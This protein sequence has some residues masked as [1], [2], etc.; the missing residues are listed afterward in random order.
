G[1]L[2]GIEH[3]QEFI[4][5]SREVSK[6]KPIIITKSGST[7]AGTRAASSHTGSLTGSEVAF[8]A[9]FKQAGI[10]RAR[11]IEELFNYALAFAYQPLPQGPNLA[12][13]TNA[14]GPGILA[15]DSAEKNGINLLSLSK[16]TTDKLMALLPPAA[17]VYNPVDILGDA[18]AQRYQQALE[19][20]LEDPNVHGALVILT[21]QAMTEVTQTAEVIGEISMTAGKPIMTSFMGEYAV[22]EGIERLAKYKIPNYSY[23]EHAIESFSMM[24]RYRGWQGQ[25]PLTYCP[26]EGDKARVRRIIEQACESGRLEIG[27]LKAREIL[28]AYQ[29]E[30][31]AG[32]VAED[33]D[34]AA[35]LAEGIGYPVVM[36][37]VSPDIL[38]KSDVG[39]VK[40]G[41]KNAEE[42]QTA[43]QEIMFRVRKFMPQALINGVSIQKM[44]DGSRE[45]IL[46]MARDP[47]FGPLIMFGLGGIYVEVLKD[48]SFRVAPI[49]KEE[50]QAMIREIKAYP[51]LK[52]VRGQK[53]VDMEAITDALLRLSQLVVDFPEILEADINP[54]IMKESGQGAVA[55]DARFTISPS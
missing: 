8:E 35:A 12:I 22:S 5:K 30:V 45:V 3:G 26:F 53:S 10:I 1:Y 37:I 54:L 47:Q 46:G 44:Y 9:A 15:A 31:P 32:Q 23:P 19:V 13:V 6:V 41:L 36:K 49:C 11:T 43:F 27:D 33:S 18:R 38:H 50:A 7:S 42:V 29:F 52:G 51:L 16:E 39:G 34:M 2:E 14:G 4:H 25:P 17:S 55:V 40:V 21:P 24:W 28:A 48:V 20:V